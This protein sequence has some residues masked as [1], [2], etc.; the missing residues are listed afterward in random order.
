METKSDQVTLLRTLAALVLI[1]AAGMI[2][3]RVFFGIETSFT[4]VVCLITIGIANLT[5]A[6]QVTHNSDQVD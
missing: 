4:L 3:A 6:H 1:L 5:I 2:G